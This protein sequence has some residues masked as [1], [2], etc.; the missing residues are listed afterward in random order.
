MPDVPTYPKLRDDVTF[1]R[2]VLRGQETFIAKDPVRRKYMQFDRLG[3]QLCQ[4]L[5]GGHTLEELVE[6]LSNAFPDFDFDVDYVR[7]Y[8]QHLIEMKLV[9]Q[10]RFEYNVLLMERVRRER[11][12]HNTLLHMTFPAL[13]PDALLG[14]LMQ[15]LRWMT[16]RPFVLFYAIFVLGSYLLLLLDFEHTWHG[17]AFFYVFTGWSVGQIVLLYV[18]I[19]LIIVIHEFGHGLT[20]KYYGGEVHQMGF[21]LIYLIN[22][23][24]Y[25]NVSDSYRFP[26]KID[27]LMVI[28][29]GPIVEMFIGSAF[30]YVWWLT[31]RTLLIHDFA[32]KI[33]IFSSISS[34]LFNMNPLLRYDGYYALSEMIE[35]PN[36]RKRAFQYLGYLIKH[37]LFRLPAEAPAGGRKEK[38]IYLLFGVAAFV[39]SLMIIALIFSLLRRWLVGALAATGW[40]LL[41]LAMYLILKSH[42]KKGAG[43]LR[44]VALD[45]SGMI[46]RNLPLVVTALLLAVTLPAV[47]RVPTVDKR[48]AILEA[49]EQTDIEAPAPGVVR[50]LYVD[51]GM[52]VTAGTVLAVVE[53]NSLELELA[54]VH[55]QRLLR[56]AEAARAAAGG[57]NTEADR[58]QDEVGRLIEGEGLLSDRCDRLRITTPIPGRVLTSHLADL[59]YRFVR[60]GELLMQVGR[61]DSLRVRLEIPEREM[62]DVRIGARVKYK[63]ESRP[64][65][66]AAGHVVVIDL[67]GE[68]AEDR[69]SFYGVEILIDNHNLGLLPGQRGSV[70]L[71]G[72]SRSL[73]GQLLRSTLQT[74]RLDF[75]L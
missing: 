49:L 74:L 11:E 70:R 56:Q 53:S 47:I 1:S 51:T 23:A 68:R 26:R 12:K 52:D 19:I 37:R 58:L 27:R 40:V 57:R 39:Y 42:L 4:S 43:F 71:Y 54:E 66:V 10:D 22:P 59:R 48:L 20:C 75:F 2:V 7:G 72:R 33:V 17:L 3:W 34:W 35:L 25:C 64:W 62:A 30:V 14:W 13:D 24:L 44:L 6:E 36:L 45:R 18:V 69:E 55:R 50:E 41:V 21:L 8:V 61:V 15:R 65:Q 46:R 32:F 38:V 63:P 73:W 60:S 31:D 16:S 29:G 67:Q 9:F 28:F 5:D